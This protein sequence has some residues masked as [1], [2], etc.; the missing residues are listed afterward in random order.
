[1]KLQFYLDTVKYKGY[2]II[3]IMLI[4]CIL[5][6]IKFG[7][8]EIFDYILFI[9]KLK[10][11]NMLTPKELQKKLREGADLKFKVFVM[12][13]KIIEGRF[14]SICHYQGSEYFDLPDG[15]ELHD[16][17]EDKNYGAIICLRSGLIICIELQG[18]ITNVEYSSRTNKPFS[19][20]MLEQKEEIGALLKDYIDIV[21]QS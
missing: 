15:Y 10:I 1:M 2:I 3:H 11:K 12:Y 18:G 4:I 9:I 13:A 21:E 17:F 7:I 14:D 16:H 19:E 20:K 8:V 6:D 5:F